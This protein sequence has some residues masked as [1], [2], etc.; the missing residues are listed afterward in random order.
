ME[1]DP[2]RQD[3]FSQASEYLRMVLGLFGKHKIPPSPFNFRIGYEQVAGRNE[4]LRQQFDRMAVRPGNDTFDADTLW[5]LYLEHYT[6]D[7]EAFH[8]IRE[9]LK[10]I[11]QNVQD[12]VQGSGGELA[13]YSTT[14][15][16]FVEVLDQP[17]PPDVMATKAREVLSET[18]VVQKSQQA[19]ELSLVN[20]A[21]EIQTLKQELME[22]KEESVTDAL[23]GVNNR[24][25][26]DRGLDK[27]IAEAS[28]S[29]TPLT[30]V[31]LD[32]DHFKTFNDT[33]GHLIGDK[34]IR[35]VASVLQK[36]V[37]GQDLCARYGGEEFAL[38]LPHTKAIGAESLAN[39]LRKTIA[40]K[41]LKDSRTNNEYG[42]ITISAGVA[43]YRNEG[44]SY[45][46]IARA[47]AALYS[48]KKAGRNRVMID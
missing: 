22:V 34:V 12:E 29:G 46:L 5:N 30:L 32:I 16:G 8:R 14:L 25:A 43:E 38:V 40:A 6:F 26:L 1:I 18:Q 15:E 17:L 11:I 21:K 9:D 42:T 33:Y 48:A 7:E 20:M 35:Y 10:A 23:T 19:M 36:G 24:K 13:S 2:Y 4:P 28:E 39:S 41:K 44:S 31:L 47:D 3:D 27:A 37:K 45:D